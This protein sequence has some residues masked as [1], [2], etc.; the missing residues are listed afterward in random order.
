MVDVVLP[1]TKGIETR[2]SCVTAPTPA[3]AVLQRLE[4]TVPK[5]LKRTTV[6]CY[7]LVAVLA[8]KVSPPRILMMG[9]PPFPS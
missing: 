4:L 6:M 3:Q 8:E 1:T 5:Y 7:Q 9:V 2:K